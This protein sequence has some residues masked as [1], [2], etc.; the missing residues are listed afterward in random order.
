MI[1]FS[2]ADMALAGMESKIPADEV[3][4]AMKEVGD[5]MPCA[6]KETTQG[7]LANTPTAKQMKEQVFGKKEV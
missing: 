3:I 2:A 5:S 1:A 6:M 7:G 4:D